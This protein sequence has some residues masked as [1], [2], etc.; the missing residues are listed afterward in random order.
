MV[1]FQGI[2]PGFTAF[3]TIHSDNMNY[4]TESSN[5]THAYQHAFGHILLVVNV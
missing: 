5:Y 2:F 4:L 3:L 1:S